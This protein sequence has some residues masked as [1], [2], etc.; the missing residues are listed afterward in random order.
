MN[1]KFET[2]DALLNNSH[3]DNLVIDKHKDP[4]AKS[5]NLSEL[6]SLGQIPVI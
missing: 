1:P 5:S 2:F 6:S 3:G 4:D